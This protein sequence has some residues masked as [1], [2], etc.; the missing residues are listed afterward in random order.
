M[1]LRSLLIIATS[2]EQLLEFLSGYGNL[3]YRCL[4]RSSFVNES[5]PTHECVMSHIY[6]Y[7]ELL[8]LL[9]RYGVALASRIDKI[10]RFF[11]KRAL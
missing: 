11:G 8:E 5:C 4:R 3:I 1:F 7:E 9:Y 2:Y 6:G 10:I